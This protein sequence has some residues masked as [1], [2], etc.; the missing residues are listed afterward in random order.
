MHVKF[1]RKMRLNMATPTISSYFNPFSD[2]HDAITDFKK[3]PCL[4]QVLIGIVLVAFSWTIIFTVP[5]FRLLVGRCQVKEELDE[6]D[7]RTQQAF[8]S[9]ARSSSTFP[10]GTSPRSIRPPALT[11]EPPAS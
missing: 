1:D 9:R 6:E 7:R 11:T 5:I 8:Q 2:N 4:K 3:L 10:A